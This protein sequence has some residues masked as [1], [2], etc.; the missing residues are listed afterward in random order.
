VERKNKLRKIIAIVVVVSFLLLSV[1]P[2]GGCENS[3]EDTFPEPNEE[4][5]LA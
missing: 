2:L 5:R 1:I 3:R 4:I